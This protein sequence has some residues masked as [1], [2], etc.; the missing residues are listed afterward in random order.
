M[1]AC[2]MESQLNWNNESQISIL[3][4]V[5][6]GL[7]EI[8]NHR[9][10]SKSLTINPLLILMHFCTRLYLAI[11]ATCSAYVPDYHSIIQLTHVC[12]SSEHA[13]A[14]VSLTTPFTSISRKSSKCSTDFFDAFTGPGLTG[15]ET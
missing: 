1:P 8:V 6:F 3:F 2:A 11:I 7:M 12:H 15:L 14:V 9:P 4:R 10:S 5:V 13:C